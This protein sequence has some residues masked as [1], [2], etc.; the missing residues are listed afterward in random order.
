MAEEDGCEFD[1]SHSQGGRAGQASGWHGA[2]TELAGLAVG[3]A[4]VGAALPTPGTLAA[5]MGLGP[6][7]AKIT[8][9]V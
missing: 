9:A 4:L 6:I 5:E 2:G 1:G 7:R 3:L 8:V